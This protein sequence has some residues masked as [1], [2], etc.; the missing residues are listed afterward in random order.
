MP[1]EVPVYLFTGFLE[2]GKTSLIQETMQDPNFNSGEPTLIVLCEEGEEE[3][4]LSAFAD[5]GRHTVVKTVEEPEELNARTLATWCREAGA[6]RVMLE[7]NGMWML[8]QLFAALPEGWI[9]YQEVMLVDSTT[10]LT[11][12]A[13][14]RSLVVDK[15]NTCEMVV[16]NRCVSSIDRMMLHQIVRA[17]NRRADIVYE[18]GDQVTF[19]DIEDPLP[20]DLDAP[21]IEIGE[22][23]YALWY[24]DAAEEPQKYQ[25]KT[26]RFKA[27]TCL[28]DR[29]PKDQFIPGRFVMTCCEADTTFM[30]FLC[31]F[32]GCRQLKQRSWITVTASIQVRKHPLYQGQA[33]PLLTAISVEP[34]EP[35]AQEIATFY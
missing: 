22:R 24:R 6:V 7:Y 3:L 31:K 17:S 32:P 9:I 16:F 15:L 14:M 19:D 12:N 23:D 27:M 11:Y 5:G 2:G 35:P 33:G 1:R 34:A 29:L 20:F 28:S 18:N 13:N 4:D 10:F 25:G 21:I 8:E 30:G 26:V